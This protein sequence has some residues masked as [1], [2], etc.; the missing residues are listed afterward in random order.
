MIYLHQKCTE[1]LELATIPVY[2][3][4]DTIEM[5]AALGFERGIMGQNSPQTASLVI[6]AIAQGFYTI[7]PEYYQTF[8]AYDVKLSPEQW[9]RWVSTGEKPS[10]AEPLELLMDII[11]KLG[12]VKSRMEKPQGEGF[13]ISGITFDESDV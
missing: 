5:L 1:H 13:D 6:E 2:L 12:Q 7:E 8:G 11:D 4:P 10:P 3:S 9:M